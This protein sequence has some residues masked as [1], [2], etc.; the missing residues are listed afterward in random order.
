MEVAVKTREGKVMLSAPDL[1]ATCQGRQDEVCI[2]GSAHMRAWLSQI[3]GLRVTR[4]LLH[5]VQAVPSSRME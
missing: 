3:R 4:M 5:M 2:C 1:A